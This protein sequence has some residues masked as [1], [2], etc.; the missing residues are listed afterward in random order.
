MFHIEEKKKNKI[1][2]EKVINI[3]IKA[4]SNFE[5]HRYASLL[6]IPFFRGVY[7]RDTLPSQIW[8]N[9]TA[10]LNL[11]SVR[12]PG[13]HWVAY[14]KR[15]GEIYYF[16]S[17]GDLR[18]CTELLHYFHTSREQPVK[19]KYNYTNK[20]QPDTVVCGHRCLQFLTGCFA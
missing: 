8:V 4:L 16:D 1:Q 7:M 15:G 3:P 13:T 10:I 20:Q 11:D 14:R 18:P 6:K 5:L 12:N 2:A 17:F 19:I 9:E